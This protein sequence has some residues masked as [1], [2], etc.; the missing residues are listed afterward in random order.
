MPFIRT[1]TTGLHYEATGAGPALL[2]V[3]GAAGNC[4]S[5]FQQVPHFARRFR[6][7]CYDQRG[8]G[9][10][11]QPADGVTGSAFVDDLRGLLDALDIA[12]AHIVAHSMG[13]WTALGLADRHPERVLSLVLS[14]TH[15][16]IE[17]DEIHTVIRLQR[18]RPSV[19]GLPY[20]LSPS[21]GARFARERPDLAYLFTAI[22]GLNPPRPGTS[23]AD[24]LRSIHGMSAE[25]AAALRVPVLFIAGEESAVV[26]PAAVTLA[27][28]LVPRSRLALV[29][30]AGHSVYFEQPGIFNQLVDGFI[31]AAAG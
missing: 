26:P 21:L 14:G 29:P 28:R 31:A 18:E 16:G 11:P 4:L 27:Q 3:H 13:G 15:G 10:S 6:V 5:W 22:S 24:H 23:M 30:G 8:W 9:R 25:R 19:E 12:A 17:S 7:I 2:F 1:H 20:P